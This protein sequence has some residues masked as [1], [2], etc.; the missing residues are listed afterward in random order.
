MA[1]SFISDVAGEPAVVPDRGQPPENT[2]A[3]LT[4]GDS[5]GLGLGV[6]VLSVRQRIGA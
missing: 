5:F 4:E 2:V 6:V 1:Q 3:R